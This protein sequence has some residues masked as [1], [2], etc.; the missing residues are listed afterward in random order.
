VP[1]QRLLEAYLASDRTADAEQIYLI[2]DHGSAHHPR[3]S[4]A[5]LAA[6][7][8]RLIAVQLP[9][10]SSW[11]NQIELYFSILKRKAL[12]PMDLPDAA[13]L[14]ERIGSFQAY[15]NQT[16]APFRWNFTVGDLQ[17]YVQRLGD[18]GQWPPPPSLR[19]RAPDPKRNPLTV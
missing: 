5:R 18:R 4:P 17:Q 14:E 1:F 15:Y 19:D 8:P 16:A 9:N 2:L 7:D 3:T 10:H 11:L 6:L 13:A 12:T